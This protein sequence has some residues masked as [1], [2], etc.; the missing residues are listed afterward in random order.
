MKSIKVNMST[1]TTGIEDVP[2]QYRGLGGRG[3]TSTGINEEVPPQCDPLGPD[4][5]GVMGIRV[6]KAERGLLTHTRWKAFY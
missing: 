1:K 5:P 4:F 3:L 2:E 6:L